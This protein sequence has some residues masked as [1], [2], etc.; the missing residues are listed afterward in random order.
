MIVLLPNK[1]LLQ[2]PQTLCSLLPCGCATA[3]SVHMRRSRTPCPLGSG[4]AQTCERTTKT[5][6]LFEDR[7]R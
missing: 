1:P 7:W 4:A 5:G 6:S 2:T 3:A